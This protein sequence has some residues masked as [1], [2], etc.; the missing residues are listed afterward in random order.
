MIAPYCADCAELQVEITALKERNKLLLQALKLSN[1]YLGKACAEELMQGCVVPPAKAF[2][3][4]SGVLEGETTLV[5]QEFID[6]ALADV[7]DVTPLRA[8]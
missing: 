2:K 8:A 1:A 4:T 6:L 3:W 7:I 5:L